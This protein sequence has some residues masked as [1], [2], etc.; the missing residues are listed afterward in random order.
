MIYTRFGSE[1][2]LLAN[3]GLHKMQYF[4]APAPLLKIRFKNDG[5]EGYRFDFTLK[6]D[7]GWDEIDKAVVALPKLK[8]SRGEKKAA[9]ESAD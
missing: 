8:L 2:E 3:C 5:T 6:A 1:I 7:G 9:L 4:T